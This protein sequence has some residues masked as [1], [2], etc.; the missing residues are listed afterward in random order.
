MTAK[1][2]SNPVVGGI[3]MTKFRILI[4]DC[5][6]KKDPSEGRLIKEFLQM[7]QL[8]KPAKASSLYYKVKS[9]K[10][11]LSKLSTGKRYNII[12]ISAH[13]PPKGKVGIGNGSTWL[14]E[15]KEI[16]ETNHKTTLVFVSACLANNQPIA[17]AFKGAK[18]FLAPKTEVDW[19]DAAL[20]SI[21]FY[22]R[23]IVDGVKMR[24]AFE[25]A[26]TRTQT[27]DDYPNYWK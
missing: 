10:E 13:G 6:P 24:N 11:F 18:Y 3:T 9:K 21:V 19:L 26:R 7:C 17:D 12:H 23:Y 20:F 16:E 2:T 27:C 1:A 5:T 8:Y 15:P 4:L 25:Y 22:K 14:A